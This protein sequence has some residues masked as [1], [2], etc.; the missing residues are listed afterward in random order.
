M[1]IPVIV[2]AVAAVMMACEVA[3]P[4]RSWPQVGG[5]W[6]RAALLDT[7]APTGRAS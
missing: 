6:L 3:R 2:I 5:W 7:A 4:G 1:I